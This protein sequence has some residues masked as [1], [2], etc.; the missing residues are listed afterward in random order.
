MW[1]IKLGGSWLSNPN[2]KKLL[3]LFNK[4]RSTPITF[5]VGGGI[6]ADAVRKSQKYLNF[7]DEFANYMA[8]KATEQYAELINKTCP[9]VRVTRKYSDL[10]SKKN[11]K[12]WLPLRHLSR[13]SSYEKNWDSTSDSIACWLNN[14]MSSDGVIFIKSINLKTFKD[15]RIKVL[16]K[17]GII[18]KNILKY[19]KKNNS[20]KI[21]G[22]EVLEIIEQE[23]SW[24]NVLKKI[25]NIKY[26]L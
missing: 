1:V 20:L 12:I 23:K 25:K 5:V 10:L 6:F 16:Q 15:L 4:F 2:L 3:K 24:Y 18:D 8:I 19:V 26:N 22:P 17:K 7:D 21:I 14:K 11:I 9:F 13:N